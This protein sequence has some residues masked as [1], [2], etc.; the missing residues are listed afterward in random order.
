MAEK[1]KILPNFQLFLNSPVS[2]IEQNERGAKVLFYRNTETD[3]RLFQV[4]AK[5]V[6]LTVPPPMQRSIHFYPPLPLLKATAQQQMKMGSLSSNFLLTLR[7]Y[8]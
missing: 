2:V 4:N 8:H 3:R 1:M 7:F 6:V 5:Y